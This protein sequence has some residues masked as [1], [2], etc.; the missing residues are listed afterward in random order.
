[1]NAD[2]PKQI[3]NEAR[4]SSTPDVLLDL[5]RNRIEV[6]GRAAQRVVDIVLQSATP[7]NREAAP[8]GKRGLSIV[9]YDSRPE[10]TQE[11]TDHTRHTVNPDG[12]DVITV[13]LA[14]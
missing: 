12:E 1:M 7:T 13:H 2:I 14:T 6:T 11:R 3:M 4:D 10:R 8:G 5:N 9:D